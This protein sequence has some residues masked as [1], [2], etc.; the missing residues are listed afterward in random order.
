[1]YGL[2]ISEEIL[3]ADRMLLCLPK[4]AIFGNLGEIIL[5]KF[6]LKL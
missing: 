5:H 2:E 4:I 6:Q 3:I 1:M